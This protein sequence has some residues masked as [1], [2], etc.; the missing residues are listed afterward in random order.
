MQNPFEIFLHPPVH[1]APNLET[2]E[3][4]QFQKEINYHNDYQIIAC[5]EFNELI[6]KL[7]EYK[8]AHHI[9]LPSTKCK[10]PDSLFLNNWFS[11][12]P[13]KKLLIYP[14]WAKN[15]RTE[16][17]SE[18]INQILNH[19]LIAEILD[20]RNQEKNLGYCEGTG[21]LIFDHQQKKV[22]GCI[23]KRTSPALVDHIG[24]E[25]GYTPIVF[26]ALDTNGFQ[27]YHTNVMLSIGQHIVFICSE[28][29]EN[30]LE[31]KLVMKHLNVRDREIIE[32][33]YAQMNS[34]LGNVFEV[35]NMVGTPILCM[36]STAK[37][38]LNQKQLKQITK[39]CDILE[40]AIP[41]IESVG[42]GS[43]RCMMAGHY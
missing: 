18:K 15:R 3:N 41:T 31:R 30:I 25:I 34:F 17:D 6:N 23:S 37:N 7:L 40:V 28:S 22:F 19:T 38:A 43:V 20:F 4:N 27:I 36:S 42:G 12:L 5:N 35:N 9:L 21:S 24:K 11:I 13:S 16:V 29:I 2:F 26:E 8:I 10:S 14:M 1:F 39:H 32:I 33:N